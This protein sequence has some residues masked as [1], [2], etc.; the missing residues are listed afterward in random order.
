[1]L[2]TI[3]SE[4]GGGQGGEGEGDS[5]RNEKKPALKPETLKQEWRDI[6][7][8][9]QMDLETFSNSYGEGAGEMQQQLRQI[10]KETYDYAD[11]LK[12]FAVLGE[13]IEI[14]DE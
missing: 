2:A 7:E 6:A 3:E 11:F 12:H 14:N 1:M 9:I 8:R 13:N 4:D 5:D 10:N